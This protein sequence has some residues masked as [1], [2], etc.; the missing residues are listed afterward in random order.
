MTAREISAFDEMFNMIFEAASQKKKENVIAGDDP[1][2][3]K[4][5]GRDIGDLFGKLRRHSKKMKWSTDADE[6]LDRK[7]EEMDLCDTDQQLLEWAMTSVFDESKKYEEVARKAIAEAL[8]YN[9]T[10][11]ELPM[12][13]PPTYPKVV[14][15]LMK[16]FREKYQDPH[17]ALS[18]FDYARRLS[19]ASYVF[20][21][22]TYAYN[23]LI[24]TRWTCFQDLKGV[25]DALEEMSVNMVEPDTGTRRLIENVRRDLVQENM[26]EEENGESWT[27][28]SH[29]EKLLAQSTVNRAPRSSSES[30]E[31]KWDDWKN[32]TEEEDENYEFGG[33]ERDPKR[34]F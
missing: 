21:C 5:I 17:L 13:Q 3:G 11:Q 26:W 22:S 25:Y 27:M 2:I 14:G 10:S 29:I 24:E 6:L 31:P 1:L 4:G 18:I 34:R 33:W 32:E 28:L 7:K 20:G 30:S 23:E 15:L 19:V 8:S 9:S 16:A 12:L